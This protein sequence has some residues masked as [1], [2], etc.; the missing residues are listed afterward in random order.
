MACR[1]QEKTQVWVAGAEMCAERAAAEG[2]SPPSTRRLVA[3]EQ[4]T[5][6][7]DARRAAKFLSDGCKWDQ[8]PGATQQTAD[9]SH[10][11]SQKRCGTP[12]SFRADVS[13]W[14]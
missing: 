10:G 12:C 6:T 4:T 3:T 9:E 8:W 14:V 7:R 5:I 2:Q 11:I 1:M 13:I